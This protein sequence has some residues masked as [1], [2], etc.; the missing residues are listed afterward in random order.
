MFRR[1]I[2]LKLISDVIIGFEEGLP[3]VKF[4]LQN[5]RGT[6]QITQNIK[7]DIIKKVRKNLKFF[8]KVRSLGFNVVT[9]TVDKA[10]FINPIPTQK[11]LEFTAGAFL[12]SNMSDLYK[13][14]KNNKKIGHLAVHF[15]IYNHSYH[16]HDDEYA[17]K[18]MQRF[19]PYHKEKRE[20][21]KKHKI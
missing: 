19:Y 14:I 18:Y 5:E 6:Y 20:V 13:H 10:R 17:D 1:I 12:C 9:I 7:K 16:S 11:A 4:Q 3:T 2:L 8:E 15:P 21:L